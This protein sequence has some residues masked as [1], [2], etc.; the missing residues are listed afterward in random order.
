MEVLGRQI[1]HGIGDGVQIVDQL[2]PPDAQCLRKMSLFH[3]P[4]Q[5]GD[6]GAALNDRACN[7]EDGSLDGLVDFGQE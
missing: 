3:H 5:V 4:R 6:L 1:G 7:A 2:C